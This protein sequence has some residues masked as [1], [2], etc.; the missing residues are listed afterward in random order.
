VMATHGDFIPQMRQSS[1]SWPQ[2]S[3]SRSSCETIPVGHCRRHWSSVNSASRPPESAE[4]RH[5]GRSS[6]SRVI[7]QSGSMALPSVSTG[8]QSLRLHS[9]TSYPSVC[10]P[11]EMASATFVV[12]PPCYKTSIK[13]QGTA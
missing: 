10:R 4:L 5:V 8:E 1:Q 9:S 3:R 6:G 13:Q 11:D 7:A 12:V 2:T